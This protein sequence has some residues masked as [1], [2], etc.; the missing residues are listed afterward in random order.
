MRPKA[1]SKKRLVLVIYP[2]GF[3]VVLVIWL[4]RFVVWLFHF[5]G[6]ELFGI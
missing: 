4:S 6:L 3:K 1:P 5:Q 2:L